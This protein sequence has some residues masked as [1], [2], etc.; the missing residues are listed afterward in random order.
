MLKSATGLSTD[1]PPRAAPRAGRGFS[2]IELLVVIVILGI[3]AG[4]A[5]LSMGVLRGEAPAETEARRLAA[6]VELLAEEALVQGRDYGIEFFEDGYRFLAWDP[7]SGLWSEVVDETTLRHRTLPAELRV[8]LAVE[9]REVVVQAGE[10]D[11]RRT[12][13][14]DEIVPQVAVFSSGELTPFEVFLVSGSVTD[15]WVLRGQM[16]GELELVDPENFR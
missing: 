12:Q 6:L 7:D 2:L 16:R 11:T 15:A 8:A 14:K 10:P 9:G 5:V 13:Q 3:M 4:M 1:L